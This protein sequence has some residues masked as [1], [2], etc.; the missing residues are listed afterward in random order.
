MSKF[1]KQLKE[2]AIFMGDILYNAAVIIVLVVL[3]RSFLLSPF[4]VEGS[5]MESTLEDKEFILI[6][7]LSYLVGEVDRG[8]PIVFLPPILNSDDPKFEKVVQTD[9]DG[10]GRLEIKDMEAVK[11]NDYCQNKILSHLWLCTDIPISEDSVYFAPTQ[12][13]LGSTEAQTNWEEAEKTQLT[14]KDI[15]NGY[16]ELSGEPNLNYNIRIYNST[17]PEYFVKRVIGIPGDTVKI[18]NGRVFLKKGT[19]EDFFEINETFLNREN[20]HQTYLTNQKGPVSFVVPKGQYFVMGDNRN[21]SNDSRSWI[22][23]ITQEPISFVPEKNISGKVAVVLWPLTH[24]RFISGA[25]L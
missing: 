13:A 3:I 16:F 9:S 2:A 10:V 21:R 12:V 23:P 24:L 25:E 4:R 22:E 15:N 5:S 1:K 17:G 20:Y 7:K 14:E 11:S 19:D 18:E 6:D 8:D